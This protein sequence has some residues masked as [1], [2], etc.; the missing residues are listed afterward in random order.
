MPQLEAWQKVLVSQA[1]LTSDHG[2]ST[3]TFCHGGQDGQLTMEEAHVGLVADPSAQT[4]PVCEQC[5]AGMADRH[6]GSMHRQLTGYRTM[7]ATRA[8]VSQLSGNLEAMFQ[9]Q[10]SNCHATCGQCH[11]SRPHSV[12]KGFVQGH[13]FNRRPSM[14]ENCTAC[15]GSRVGAEFRGEHAGIPADTHYNQGMQC[16]ACHEADEL[17]G[18]GNQGLNR[19][20]VSD[21]PRCE[22]CHSVASSN[23]YHTLH[24]D[25]LSCQV[26]HSVTY[27]NCYSCHV[28][29]NERGLEQPSELDFKIGLNPVLSVRQPYE[30]VVVRHVPIAP[31]SFDEWEPAGLPNFDALPTWK[32]STPHNIQKNTPQT[33]D[34]TTTC[35]NNPSIFLTAD[36]L[37][38]LSSE[39]ISANQSVIVQNVPQ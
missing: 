32:L 17:H 23:P 12:G 22:T 18:Q 25:K 24:G 20:E 5:H 21:A 16:V 11:V 27:K 9:Q 1:F 36:D 35:H 19:Y 30:Y 4:I 29:R 13:V 31:N 26:C 8:G 33:A 39:E 38:G 2:D 3:C 34:C 14:T 28:G 10:C 7:I 6:N 37:T 15:H